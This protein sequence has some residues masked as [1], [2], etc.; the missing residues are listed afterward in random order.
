MEI[1]DLDQA[2]LPARGRVDRR[3]AASLGVAGA[4]LALFV[5]LARPPAAPPSTEITVTVATVTPTARPADVVTSAGPLSVP[6]RY[7]N[8][9]LLKMPLNEPLPATLHRALIVRGT[10]ALA[11]ADAP[12]VI[13]WAERGTWYSIS[14][15]ELTIDEL[16]AIA[17]DLP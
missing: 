9:T 12:A 17:E 2:P 11:A 1:I 13:V 4:A 14:S 15:W 10:P 5:L 6:P 7:T 16:V 8:V 3:V